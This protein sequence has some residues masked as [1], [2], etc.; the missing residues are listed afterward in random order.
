MGGIG[1]TNI[2]GMKFFLQGCMLNT[3]RDAL[4]MSI[5]SIFY[6]I[7]VLKILLAYEMQFFVA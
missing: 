5:N 1:K 3:S 4:T 7:F 6:S 2:L